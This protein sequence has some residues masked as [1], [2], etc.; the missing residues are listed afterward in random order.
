MRRPTCRWSRTRTLDT[1][2]QYLDRESLLALHWFSRADQWTEATNL[3][4]RPVTMARTCRRTRRPGLERAG[5]VP[6]PE[7]WD[8]AHRRTRRPALESPTY[9]TWQCRQNRQPNLVFDETPALLHRERSRLLQ[10]PP[11]AHRSCAGW[12]SR[13]GNKI[14]QEARCLRFDATLPPTRSRPRASRPNEFRK[15][16]G[17]GGPEHNRTHHRPATQGRSS[18][19]QDLHS[20]Y[21]CR[22]RRASIAQVPDGTCRASPGRLVNHAGSWCGGE[23]QRRHLRFSLD[24][25]GPPGVVVWHELKKLDT[26]RAWWSGRHFCSTNSPTRRL[27]RPNQPPPCWPRPR[28]RSSP[29]HPTPPTRGRR[30]TLAR[31]RYVRRQAVEAG[32]ETIRPLL[33]AC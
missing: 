29:T 5:C 23:R 1:R 24:C 15:P 25:R 16:F 32:V 2:P 22:F 11:R 20:T 26:W 28:R 33:S 8:N 13:A 7:E 31:A 10:R 3:Q 30:A 18:P 14:A 6:H 19:W 27:G 12:A 4:K 21:E 9:P 17:R